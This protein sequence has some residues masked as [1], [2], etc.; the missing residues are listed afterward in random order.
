VKF[1]VIAEKTAKDLSGFILCH[2][3][4]NKSNHH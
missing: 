2:T 4:H 3:Q 1:Q